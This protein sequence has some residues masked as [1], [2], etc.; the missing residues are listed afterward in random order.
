MKRVLRYVAMAFLPVLALGCQNLNAA[1]EMPAIMPIGTD[2]VQD[3]NPVW[4]PRPP[5]Y[6]SALYE[7]VLQVLGD[8]G[9]EFA[10]TNRYSGHVEAVPRI[11]PGLLLFLKPGSPDLYDRFLSSLQTYRHRVSVIIETADPQAADHGGYFVKFIVRKELEDLPRPLRSAVGGAVFRSEHTVERQT[12]VIDATI[13]EPGWIY[14]GRDT[15]LEQELIRRFK[16]SLPDAS[17]VPR[18]A[19]APR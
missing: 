11:A 2:H 8:Y 5:E 13:F 4:I 14:R 18:T 16:N 7:T 10:E 3:Q 15:A 19:P 9:F 17:C 12:E 6:Y 1:L